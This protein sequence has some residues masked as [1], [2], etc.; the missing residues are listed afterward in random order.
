MS[1]N[2]QGVGQDSQ[3][4]KIKEVKSW[5]VTI[6]RAVAWKTARYVKKDIDALIVGISDGEGNI[7]YGYL[8]SMLLEG[9]SAPS[10][11]ALLHVVLKPVILRGGFPGIQPLM[12]ELDLSLLHNHQLKFAIESALL[13]LTAKR[14]GTPLYNLL[15][16]LCWEEV[17]VM[18][19][20]G[21][22][23]PEE[24]AVEAIKFVEKGYRYVKLKVGID[25]KRDVAAFKAV[26][27]AVGPD[28]FLSIDA[29]RSYEVMQ[30]IRI[31]KQLE[32]WDLGLIEQPIRADDIRGMAFIRQHINTPLMAD[33]A[34]LNPFDAQRL[35]DANAIDAVSIKLW[36]VGGFFKA[37]QIAAVCNTANIG[38]HVA[39]TPGSILM[40]AGQLHFAAST[41]NMV[42]GAEIGEFDGLSDDPAS[43]IN[44]LNGSLRPP[45]KPGIGVDLDLTNARETQN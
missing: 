4:L 2:N 21:L 23:S 35:I 27:E 30:T 28:I 5:R 45:K 22:K 25:E 3:E 10:A 38:C 37:K 19:M 44:I 6:H 43:G 16:G 41:L 9:E 33:E 26:R 8:P 31:V 24:T 11:E 32:K 18:R 29:N 13:D 42:A 17:P 7:G 20:V 40:E 34:V 15:G 36:K 12:K 14:I 1:D 39:S